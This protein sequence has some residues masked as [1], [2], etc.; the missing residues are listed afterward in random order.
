MLFFKARRL[1]ATVIAADVTSQD[2]ESET[3]RWWR[4][5]DD[6]AVAD[7]LLGGHDWSDLLVLVDRQSQL[8]RAVRIGQLH[9]SDE[10]L[11]AALNGASSEVTL[12]VIDGRPAFAN[13]A[14]LSDAMLFDGVRSGA[15]VFQDWL[16]EAALRS[17]SLSPG[18]AIAA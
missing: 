17:T 13:A 2:S 3:Q 4:A 5:T 6:A 18:S 8:G 7:T 14:M 12:T 9:F 1:L 15:P 11:V 16:A 10:E